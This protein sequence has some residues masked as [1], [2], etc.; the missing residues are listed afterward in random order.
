VPPFDCFG[1]TKVEKQPVPFDSS[2]RFG[3]SF[4]E[5]ELAGDV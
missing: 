4:G 1:A 2:L 3:F 5:D